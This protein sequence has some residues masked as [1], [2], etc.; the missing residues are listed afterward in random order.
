MKHQEHILAVPASCFNTVDSNLHIVNADLT[1]KDLVVMQRA[2]LESDPSYRQIISYSIVTHDGKVLAYRRTP[3]GNEGRLHGQVSIGFGGHVDMVDI[4]FSY[5]TLDYEKTL[6]NVTEREIE[7]EVW[8]EK[9]DNIRILNSYIVSSVNEVDSVHAG[10]L[11]VVESLNGVVGNAEDQVDLLGWFTP[12]ELL[13]VYHE[14]L[15]S[16]SRGVLEQVDVFSL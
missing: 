3:K 13:R 4:E 1:N 16:W 2:G 8:I 6:R 9:V 15:E 11:S 14:D 7:E 12:E 10:A 5:G